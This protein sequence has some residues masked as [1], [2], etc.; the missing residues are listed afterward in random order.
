M[1]SGVKCCFVDGQLSKNAYW[2]IDEVETNVYRLAAVQG[3]TGYVKDRY[4]G[5]QPD[6]KTNARG[7]NVTTT[8]GAYFDV[9]YATNPT[10][11]QW[12]LVDVDATYGAYNAATELETLLSMAKTKRV[13]AEREQATLDNLESTKEQLVQ[14]QRTLRKKLNLIHFDD[15]TFRDVAIANYDRD[16]DGELSYAEAALTT[17]FGENFLMNTNVEDLTPLQYFTS[18]NTLYGN[19]FVGCTQLRAITLPKGITTMYY[20]VF[21]ELSLPS[22]LSY[23]GSNSFQGCTALKTL[24]IAVTDPAYIQLAADVFKDVDLS[25]V[26][27]YVPQGSKELYAAA[28]VWKDFGHIEEMRAATLPDFAPIDTEET[29]IIYNLAAGGFIRNGEAYG[30]QAVVGN[31]GFAYQLRRTN[32]MPE[33]TYY[34]YSTS[35][36]SNNKVLFRTDTDSKVGTGVKACFVDGSVSAKAYWTFAPVEGRENVFTLQVPKGAAGYVEGQYLGVYTQHATNAVEAGAP[37]YGLYW[38]IVDGDPTYNADACHWALIRVSDIEAMNNWRRSWAALRNEDSTSP[39]SR[40]CMTTSMPHRNSSKPPRQRCASGWATSPLTT[41]ASS[42]CAS[43]A[44][45]SMRMTS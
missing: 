26:T 44:M 35:I 7:A 29:Y 34:L 24:R 27:L 10:N 18:V 1:G 2:T 30:T 20:R 37:T 13:N 8:M 5:I 15:A 43:T 9:S 36:T 41:T 22:T 16:G 23:I 6:H 21:E 28:D 3:S 4:L 32:S 39:T 19:S 33:N 40:P 31:T 14:A 45:T 12:M 38:D 11:C 42:N 25:A 17:D